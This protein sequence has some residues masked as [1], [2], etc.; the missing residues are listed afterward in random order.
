[1][2]RSLGGTKVHM[3]GRMFSSK[4]KPSAEDCI[5]AIDTIYDRTCGIWC[6]VYFGHGIEKWYM[7]ILL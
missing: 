3:G 5:E 4:I 7:L 1:M 2:Y 6:F